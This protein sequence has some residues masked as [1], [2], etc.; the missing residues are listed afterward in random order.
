MRSVSR[1]VGWVLVAGG[2]ASVFVGISPL[3]EVRFE[4]YALG[5]GLFAAG[6]WVL[7]GKD[8]RDTIRKGLRAARELRR[9]AARGGDRRS[10]HGPAQSPGLVDRLLP[11]RI[12]K[13][14]QEHGGAL[15]VARVAMEL[16]VPLDQA[17]AGLEE[18][19]RSGNALPDYDLSRGHALYRF[20]EFSDPDTPRL[21]D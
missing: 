21:P 2:A 8:L 3:F 4:A 16:N 18:C 7:A 11:V 12:L 10:A 9:G 14:A 1:I 5:V 19:V 20:P 6:A 17:Q 13:L 15:T